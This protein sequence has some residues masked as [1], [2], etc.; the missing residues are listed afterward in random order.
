MKGCG[1]VPAV[2]V[3]S[4]PSRWRTEELYVSL[5]DHPH[6]TTRTLGVR[7]LPEHLATACL[8]RLREI[9]ARDSSHVAR[10]AAAQRVR[11]LMAQLHPD[12]AGRLTVIQETGG[13]LALADANAGAV[14]LVP[15]PV[16]S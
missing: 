10:D 9:A 12:A 14:A 8:P 3:R 16:K 13:E 2:F 6:A 5:L 11:Q 15:E 1:T 7:H 4:P